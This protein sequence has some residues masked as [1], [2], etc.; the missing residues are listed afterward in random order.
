MRT[1]VQ[2]DKPSSWLTKGKPKTL[3]R[4]AITSFWKNL[5]YS[6]REASS[7]KLPDPLASYSP[8]KTLWHDSQGQSIGYKFFSATYKHVTLGKLPDP[9]GK[10][11]LSSVRQV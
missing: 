2:D 11:D 6:V 10:S 4:K 1:Y 9:S 7:L 8:G 3:F 5:T